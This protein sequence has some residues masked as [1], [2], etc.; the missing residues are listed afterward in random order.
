MSLGYKD[1]YQSNGVSRGSLSAGVNLNIG[2]LQ[3]DYAYDRTDVYQQENQHYFSMSVH[4]PVVHGVGGASPPGHS[5]M[6]VAA[7]PVVK[8]VVEKSVVAS[9]SV[10]SISAPKAASQPSRIPEAVSMPL[11]ITAPISVSKPEPV[12]VSMPEVPKAASPEIKVQIR[13]IPSEAKSQPV[14]T[15][16]PAKEATPELVADVLSEDIA[17]MIW[18]KLAGIKMSEHVNPWS[19]WVDKARA[20][21]AQAL[22]VLRTVWGRLF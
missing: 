1:K 14:V 9:P 20:L 22:Y 13:R 7:K 5:N 6:T 10:V 21:G 11:A 17:P 2:A 19:R 18:P 12:V 15:R 8:P 16:P 3:F 4:F